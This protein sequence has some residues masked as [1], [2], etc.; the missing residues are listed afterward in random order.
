MVEVAGTPRAE[1]AIAESV[2]QPQLGPIAPRVTISRLFWLQLVSMGAMEMSGPFWPLYLKALSRSGWVFSV[3]GIG[4]Y[5][6][7]MLGIMLTSAFWGRIGDRY[8]NKLMMIRALVGLSVTQLLIAFTTDVWTILGLRFLQ[9]AW[10][11]Y[12]APAQAYGVQIEAPK[13]R[14]QLFAHL[15]IATNVGSLAG[16]VVGGIILDHASFTVINIS[17][18]LLCA[19]CAATA[20]FTLP[21]IAPTRTEATGEKTESPT[22]VMCD[23]RNAPPIVGLLVL[24]GLLLTSRMITQTPFSLYVQSVYSVGNWVTGLCYGLLALGFVVS[25]SRWARMFS[26]TS[27][28]GLLRRLIAVIAGCALLTVTVGLTRTLFVFIALYFAWGV[29]LGATT[30]VLMSAISAATSM[31][32]QGH[33]LGIAQA[34]QQFSSIA[35]IALG[36]WFSEAAGLDSIFF[37]VALFYVV[38]LGVAVVLWRRRVTVRSSSL[39][40]DLYDSMNP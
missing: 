35:G 12:I 33:V 30:P 31:H 11:G 10:A 36:V 40:S 28:A 20:W 6:G 4:V 15:Q 26:G 1:A 3:A 34:T 18:G 13:R 2:P 27:P 29:L 38:S 16:A 22:T 5:V 17:A 24:L 25:A 7:P 21:N 9:G 23:P 8:G 39:S 19:L 14:A 37:F 32:R